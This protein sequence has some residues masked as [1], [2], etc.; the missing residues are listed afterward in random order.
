M[1]PTTVNDVQSA[2][3]VRIRKRHLAGS[4]A[5]RLCDVVAG[6]DVTMIVAD[7]SVNGRE[8]DVFLGVAGGRVCVGETH[9]LATAGRAGAT[10]DGAAGSGRSTAGS[11]QPLR[12]VD[13][14]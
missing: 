13:R 7:V 8:V 10:Q 6:N 4:V 1:V 12:Y 5:D 9:R 11:L 3:A 2:A 14:L